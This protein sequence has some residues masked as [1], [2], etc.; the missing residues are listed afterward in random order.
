VKI[1]LAV[2]YVLQA[3]LAHKD[4]Q[5]HCNVLL[6]HMLTKLDY[7]NAKSALQIHTAMESLHLTIDVI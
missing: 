7:P 2:P 6:V 3:L 5:L 4:L 1:L